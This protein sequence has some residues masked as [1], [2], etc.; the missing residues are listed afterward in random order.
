MFTP[1]NPG[2]GSGNLFVPA[3]PKIDSVGRAVSA[4]LGNEES[5]ITIFIHKNQAGL[6]KVTMAESSGVDPLVITRDNAILMAGLDLKGVPDDAGSIVFADIL[7]SEKNALGRT[8]W[9]FLGEGISHYQSAGFTA[10]D[11]PLELPPSSLAVAVNRLL[12]RSTVEAASA[13]LGEL[14]GDP[15]PPANPSSYDIFLSIQQGT[16]RVGVFFASSGTFLTKIDG[17][18]YALPGLAVIDLSPDAGQAWE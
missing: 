3:T 11:D 4:V 12:S 8:A 16:N 5:D 17:G 13:I 15:L 6:V 14:V 2:V 18:E 9:D 1:L 7:Q 10:Q